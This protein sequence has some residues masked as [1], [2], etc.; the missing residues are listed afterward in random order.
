MRN[1]TEIR[2][3]ML[4]HGHTIDSI[5]K[6][7]GYANHTPVSLTI[8]GQENLRKVL[9]YLRDQGCPEEYLDMPKDMKEAA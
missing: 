9:L 7:L 4:R 3:W 2:V 6:A 8:S 1:T 5:R